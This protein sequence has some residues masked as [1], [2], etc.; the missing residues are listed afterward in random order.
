MAGPIPRKLS[1][2]QTP[3]SRTRC[4]RTSLS[5]NPRRQFAFPRN[6]ANA[7][8]SCE[9]G[10]RRHGTPKEIRKSRLPPK[11][12]SPLQ[13]VRM[14]GFF[15]IAVEDAD[16]DGDGV[17]DWDE[18]NLPGFDPA[19]AQSAV[20]GQNDSVSLQQR[21]ST[22]AVALKIEPVVASAYEKEAISGKVRITRGG[23][24]GACD[25]ADS[26]A[27]A[28]QMRRK[29]PLP[30][31]TIDYWIQ[32]DWLLPEDYVL[33]QNVLSAELQ[34]RTRPRCPARS[35]RNAYALDLAG[36]R[37]Y[38]WHQSKRL[39]CDLGR[40]SRSRQRSA[41]HRLSLATEPE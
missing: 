38:H 24:L 37:L 7:T 16:S 33:P 34:R 31:Q 27:A 9:A 35:A 32:M 1:R 23:G 29:A 39:R 18:L 8:A 14:Q 6:P 25:G 21:L 15:R 11:S 19:N 3:W 10:M 12:S 4:R 17:S 28:T 20:P 2:E 40:Y 5:P 41:F 13:L 30:Q 36:C 22:G 26:G